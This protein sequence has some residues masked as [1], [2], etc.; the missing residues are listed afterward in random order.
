MKDIR[1][2][3]DRIEGD[4]EQTISDSVCQDLNIDETF[5]SIDYTFSCIGQQYLYNLLRHVLPNSPI[6]KNEAWLL[7]Y[8]EDEKNQI[9]LKKYLSR[10]SDP[11]AY[12]ICS[13]FFDKHSILSH[14]VVI[15]YHILRFTPLFFLLLFL[16][17]SS[18][19]VLLIGI[20]AFL[21]NLG[22]HFKYKSKAFVYSW[23][24]P[25]LYK[26]FINYENLSKLQIVKD[27]DLNSKEKIAKTKKLRSLSS[28]FRYNVKLEKG[29]FSITWVVMELIRVFFLFEPISL[30]RIFKEIEKTKSELLGIF[31]DFGIIDTLQSISQMRRVHTVWSQPNFREDNVL[32]AD[33]MIHPLIVNCVPN[34]FVITDK[35]ILI[36][37]SNM[38]GKTSFIRIV[39]LNILLS[40]TINTCFAEKFNFGKT[41]IFTAI[42]IKDNL[43][44]GQSYYLSE[45]LHLKTI[46]D[47]TQKGRNLI[48]LDELFKGTNTIERVAGASSVLNFLSRNPQNTILMATH[49]HE[50]LTLCQ[51]DYRAYYFS[52]KVENNELR[53]DYKIEYEPGQNKN[54]I[55]ILALYNYP[56]EIVNNANQTIENMQS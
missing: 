49:D 38:S 36:L 21:V 6:K 31:N 25:Q 14:R 50:L 10:L 24:I 41:K 1:V 48:L 51:V 33:N 39:G 17:T 20:V 9:Q 8:Q 34:S 18:Q 2:F 13:L 43:V 52:E 44:E 40:Q 55:K 47:E 23:S 7:K 37:G 26:L 54:A 16:T 27:L 45:V 46:V 19:V 35:S 29:I 32:E 3:F 30:N 53:F 28:S 4:F 22:I 12:S 5:E 42:T 56:S 11:D 15:L